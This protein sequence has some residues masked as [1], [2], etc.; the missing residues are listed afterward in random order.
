MVFREPPPATPRQFAR[1]VDTIGG[2]LDAFAAEETVCASPP[3]SST[4]TS[5]RPSI[6]SPT[7]SSPHLYPEDIVREQ[8][9]LE[10]IKMDEDNPDYL[11]HELF[12][13]NFWKN[14][15]LGRPHPSETHR[16]RLKLRPPTVFDFYR[17]G[18]TPATGLLPPE[19]STWPS[20]TR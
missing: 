6:F 11:V 3:R 13:Q 10:E 18:P 7:S 5:P 2:N 1:E 12:T 20:S 8:A 15:A 4:K 9:I 17:G 16:H 14:D 19:T